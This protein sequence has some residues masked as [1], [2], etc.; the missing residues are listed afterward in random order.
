[1]RRVTTN[2]DSGVYL[3]MYAPGP[4]NSDEEGNPVDVLGTTTKYS[5]PK[6]GCSI[7]RRMG[8]KAYC[9][10]MAHEHGGVLT[11]MANDD[12]IAV[13]QVGKRLQEIFK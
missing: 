2:Y 13:R 10:H 5:C 8:Y 3:Q 7:K 6:S 1:M 12:N 11:V 4:D 9:V